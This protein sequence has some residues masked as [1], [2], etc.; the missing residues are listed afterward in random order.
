MHPF[1]CCFVF[2]LFLF[3]AHMCFI[4]NE[5][6]FII[7]I[8]NSRDIWIFINIFFISSS[9]HIV[10]LSALVKVRH[11][12]Q[13]VFQFTESQEMNNAVAQA[14]LNIFVH[15]K[16]YLRST[17]MQLPN[18]LRFIDIEIAKIL[19]GSQHKMIFET[20]RNISVPDGGNDGEYIKLNITQ[21]VAEWF[22]SHETSHGLA[23]KVTASKSGLVLPHKIVSLDS[24]NYIT[25][26]RIVIFCSS[27]KC[28]S[29][30]TELVTNLSDFLIAEFRHSENSKQRCK[31][32]SE[33]N[34]VTFFFSQ[35]FTD[36]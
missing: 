21:M 11:K 23:V 31:V 19:Q 4:I 10:L 2:F 14:T 22:M 3:F 28:S 7:C 1:I 34:C 12:T 35:R 24:E 13:L 18:N 6:Y 9:F 29:L 30:F 33:T 5:C 25:V 27:Y 20:F 32:G 15:S 36:A 26:S 16:K 17:D 8:T